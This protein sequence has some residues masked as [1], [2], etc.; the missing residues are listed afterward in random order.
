[1]NIRAMCRTIEDRYLPCVMCGATVPV[2]AMTT[3][4]PEAPEM[5]KPPSDAWLGF[6]QQDGKMVMIATCSEKCTQLL[7]SH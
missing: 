4:H 7:L 1:M 3:P 2:L 5:M 6:I